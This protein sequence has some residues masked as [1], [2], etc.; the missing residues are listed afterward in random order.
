[1]PTINQL[2][3]FGRQENEKKSKYKAL[4]WCQPG[5]SWVTAMTDTNNLL[6]TATSGSVTNGGLEY[7]QF[8]GRKHVGAG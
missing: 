3:R 2:V 8:T 5:G 1:M 6:A 7:G 4:P